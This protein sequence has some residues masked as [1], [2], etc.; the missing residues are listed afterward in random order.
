MDSS[1]VQQLIHNAGVV[2]QRTKI[3]TELSLLDLRRQG[4]TIKASVKDK[5]I[6]LFKGEA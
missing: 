5:Y 2:C 3:Q 4:S 1:E 6:E